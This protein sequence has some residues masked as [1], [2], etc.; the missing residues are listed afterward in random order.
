MTLLGSI[1]FS[2]RCSR[3]VELVETSGEFDRWR[4]V[5]EKEPT[6]GWEA[7][8]EWNLQPEWFKKWWVCDE[9]TH[10]TV[11][12]FHQPNGGW[13]RGPH[14]H[15]LPQGGGSSHSPP[16]QKLSKIWTA[17]AWQSQDSTAG[18]LNTDCPLGWDPSVIQPHQATPVPKRSFWVKPWRHNSITPKLLP[19]YRSL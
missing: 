12:H 5:M 13:G 8:G 2:Q 9:G 3:V 6:L 19:I 1:P 7:T 16:H 17:A 4:T 10:R 14:T 18:Q 11:M 15:I